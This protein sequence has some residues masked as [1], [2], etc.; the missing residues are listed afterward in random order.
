[1]G[2]AVWVGWM[3]RKRK[4]ANIVTPYAHGVKSSNVCLELGFADGWN[5]D[6]HVEF[7]I[8]GESPGYTNPLLL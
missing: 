7:A 6:S 5:F 2:L 4:R 3:D 8:R 1:M